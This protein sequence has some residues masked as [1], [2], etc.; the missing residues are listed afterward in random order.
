MTDTKFEYSRTYNLSSNNIT[1]VNFRIECLFGRKNALKSIEILINQ[2]PNIVT[3]R[4]NYCC[5]TT[6]ASNIDLRGRRSTT[7]EELVAGKGKTLAPPIHSKVKQ[8]SIWQTIEAFA[9]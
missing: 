4:D 8:L 9:G 6:F 3:S 7:N 5:F 1:I 2:H